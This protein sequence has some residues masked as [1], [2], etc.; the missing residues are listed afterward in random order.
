LNGFDQL[1]NS[2]AFKKYKIGNEYGND[3]PLAPPFFMG[4]PALRTKKKEPEPSCEGPGMI[5]PVVCPGGLGLT[6][7]F[8]AA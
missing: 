5:R 6:T 7:R 2:K 8:A 3:H 4:R 1:A